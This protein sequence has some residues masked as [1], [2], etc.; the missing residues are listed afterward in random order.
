L[1]QVI[2]SNCRI[3]PST[4]PPSRAIETTD[5]VKEELDL[6]RVDKA[7]VYHAWA[8]QHDPPTGN[9]EL[10]EA[11]RGDPR[12]LPAW[13]LLP[14]HTEEAGIPEQ[15]LQ[16]MTEIDAALARIFPK[17][18]NF[19]LSEWCCGP[20]LSA[21]EERRMPTMVDLGQI[22]YE[23]IHAVCS[24]HPGLPLLLSEV[25]YRADRLVYPLL[26]AHP[27]LRLETSRYQ[28]HRGI[29]S[30]CRRFGSERL[31]FG[32][33]TPDLACGPM[34]MTVRYARI[35]EDEKAGIMGGNLQEMIGG[36]RR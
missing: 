13:V 35:S 19:S 33:Q 34:A 31:V 30:I 21:L 36:I 6:A 3:G 18:H 7:V 12:F 28:T 24:A 32:S 14:H 1:P 17:D 22:S 15:L 10:L 20:L 9:R 27:N 5:Q 25:A 8:R 26:K 29:E 2:D 4:I 11:I 16:E 23:E